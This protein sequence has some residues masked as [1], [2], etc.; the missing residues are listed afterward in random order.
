MLD[1]FTVA[2]RAAKED[3]VRTGGRTLSQLVEGQA[4]ATRLLNSSTSG[5]S[6]A[7]CADGHLRDL[8]EAVVVCDGRYNRADLAL[9][10]LA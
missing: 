4:F 1:S 8:I 7:K 5:G 3:D 9:M 10:R 6:E 2:L